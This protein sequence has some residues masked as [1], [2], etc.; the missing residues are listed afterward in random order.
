MRTIPINETVTIERRVGTLD[1]VRDIIT[2]SEGPFSVINCVCR[3]GKDLLDEPCQQT[4]TRRTCLT[5]KGMATSTIRSGIGQS[6][7]REETFRLLEQAE[8][9][10]RILQPENTQDP[11]FICFC[12]GCCCGVLTSAKLFPKPAEL[13]HSNYYADVDAELCTA[14][15]TCAERC[16]MEAIALDDEVSKVDLDRCIGCGV[17]VSTCPSGAVS[18]QIKEKASEPPKNTE[19]MYRQIMKERFGPLG[20][21]KVVGKSLLGMKI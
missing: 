9:E 13:F 10:G 5:L 15:E 19:L 3:Q 16:Q 18:L 2:K 14:C 7:T 4:D 12:C 6:L 20:T 8:K 11:Q 17:C 1:N 21:L